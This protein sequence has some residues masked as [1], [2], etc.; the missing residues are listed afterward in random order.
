MA[1]FVTLDLNGWLD[2]LVVGRDDQAERK[3]SSMGFRSCLFRHDQ[4][5]LFGAQALAA[6]RDARFEG[7]LDDAIDALAIA[8]GYGKP[9]L[10]DRTSLAEALWQMVSDAAMRS[11]DPTHLAVVVPDGRF[12]GRPRVDKTTGLTGLESLYNTFVSA[13]PKQLTRSRVEL[14]WRSVAALKSAL[15]RYPD[16]LAAR[17]GQVLVVSVNR[18]VFWTTLELRRWSPSDGKQGPISILRSPVMDDC[19]SDE[20]WT[21]HRVKVVEDALT[22]N[23]FKEL[24]SLSRWT[25][26][27]EILATG[28]SPASLDGL[29]VAM[30]SAEHWSWPGPDGTWEYLGVSDRPT[31]DWRRASLPLLPRRLG[32]RLRGFVDCQDSLAVVVESPV[33]VEMTAAFEMSIRKVAPNIPIFRVTGRDT[34][35][36]ALTL[37][38][39][40]GRDESLPTWLDQVPAISLETRNRATS[41]DHSGSETA[42]KS[43]VAVGEVVP[44]GATYHTRPHGSDRKVSIAPGVEHVHL[45]L[46]RGSGNTWDERYSGRETGHRIVPSDHERVVEPLASVRPL[47]GEARIRVVEH[48]A[49][50]IVELL[51]GTRSSVKW[52]EM[53]KT[54]PQAL[55]SIPDLYVFRAS[56]EGWQTLE[57]ILRQVV[58]IETADF[59]KLSDRLYRA[60]QSQWQDQ[61]FPLGS[62][63]LPPRD[64]EVDAQREEVLST[65]TA[66]LLAHLESNVQSD[67]KLKVSAANRLH[68]PLTWLFTGCPERVV[69]ILLDALIDPQGLAGPVLHVDNDYSAWSIYSGIGRA[70]RSADALRAIFDDLIEVWERNGAAVQ[71]RFLLAAVTHPLARRVSVRTVLGESKERFERVRHFLATQLDN[72]ISGTSDLRPGGRANRSLE[73]R[74]VTMG[75]RGLCQLRYAHADWFPVDGQDAAW[76]HESLLKAMKYG[77]KF[78]QELIELSAPYLIGEGQDPTMPGGF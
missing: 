19:D 17:V 77:R 72:I 37:A 3:A 13:R 67:A 53:A 32:V 43:I 68:M 58:E 29:G 21:T 8:A 61:V 49:D 31:I 18:R 47:A 65:S 41:A 38:L 64:L 74:Y 16:Q 27:V 60:T 39:D 33:G 23:G 10:K 7:N 52:S 54:P 15:A 71:D 12:L 59:A 2:H 46:R 24:D 44:A 48:R 20:A 11:D 57:P 9:E 6:A 4:V 45:H 63:G 40:L 28:M 35:D 56:E 30:D 66:K 26:A 69:T 76:V 5:W 36:A 42:W 51:A 75:Y 78:E 1:R 22:T 34:A 55:T 14:V 62:D 50:G 73:L 25:C 70:A